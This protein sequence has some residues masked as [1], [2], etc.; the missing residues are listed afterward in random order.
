V[1]GDAADDG[2]G[3]DLA[4]GDLDADGFG[5]LVIGIPYESDDVCPPVCAPGA[6]A[7]LYGSSAGLTAAGNQLWD[8]DSPGVP[9]TAHD[10]GQFGRAVTAADFDGDGADDIAIG[11]PPDA[12]DAGSV[13]VLRGGPDGVTVSGARR[14][15]QGTP[16]VPGA[17]ANGAYFGWSLASATYGH[18][19]RADLAIGALGTQQVIVLYGRAS[20]LA[21]VN[22][23]RWSQE[24]PGVPGSTGA[25]DEF[26][27][28]LSP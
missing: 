5:D 16:G 2:Y 9:G 19:A 10:E 7:V 3:D 27:W 22:A 28:T 14:W 24:S 15:T 13:T 6:V 4:I 8:Q 12:D 18:S 1:L 26:G 17:P 20:G 23:Q 21:T 11:A 25:D